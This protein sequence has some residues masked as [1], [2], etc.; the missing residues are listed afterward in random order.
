MRE[1]PAHAP[2]RDPTVTPPSSHRHPTVIPR[3]GPGGCWPGGP[4]YAVIAAEA[5]ERSCQRSPDPNFRMSPLYRARDKVVRHHDASAPE[6]RA[7]LLR[8]R[9]YARGHGIHGQ[10]AAT[11][12]HERMGAETQFEYR[13]TNDNHIEGR[14]PVRPPRQFDALCAAEPQGKGGPLTPALSPSEG[15]RENRRQLS[16][17]RR[18]M[19]RGNRRQLSGEPRFMGRQNRSNLCDCFAAR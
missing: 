14:F 9:G 7:C 6:L 3:D 15:E 16:G 12:P 5:L 19:G 4:D 11:M 8:L 2:H 13:A 18:F 10:C 1:W 17:G